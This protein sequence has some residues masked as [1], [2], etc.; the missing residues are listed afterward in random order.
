MAGRDETYTPGYSANASDFMAQRRASTHAAF[1]TPRLRPGMRLL[2]CG[3]GPGTLT[4]DLA[5]FIAP[6][7]AVGVDREATQV[8]AARTLARER[9]VNARFEAASV[10]ELPFPDGQF[11]V[12][13]S[14]ALFE[15]LGEPLTALGEIKRV[16]KSGGFAGLRCPD[17]GGFLIHPSS[18]LLDQAITFY[19]D[20]QAANGGD[21]TAGRKLGSWLRQAGFQNVAISAAYEIYRE[22]ARIAEYLARQIEVAPDARPEAASEHQINMAA[23]L[24]RWSTDPDALFAQAWCEAVGFVE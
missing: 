20:L 15:H 1:F 13:F 23:E 11:D 21:V 10:Y 8:E 19:K 22:P 6:G 12:A 5:E 2:D 16:L 24:R 14:H 9:G 4:V 17:W 7:E 3:C 18:E